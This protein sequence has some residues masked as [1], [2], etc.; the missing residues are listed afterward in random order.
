MLS[1]ANRALRRLTVA[2]PRG[3]IWNPRGKNIRNFPV[4][5]TENGLES[6]G[7]RYS[8]KIG[9]NKSFDFRRL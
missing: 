3:W 6:E 4:F 8:Q 2:S 9:L 5:Q 7:L 1:P